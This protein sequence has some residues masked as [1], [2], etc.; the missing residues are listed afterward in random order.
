MSS[1][2]SLSFSLFEVFHLEDLVPNSKDGFLRL[3]VM[4]WVNCRD[5]LETL[6]NVRWTVYL[7]CI[8]N[9]LISQFCKCIN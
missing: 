3:N 5:N 4:L 2:T 1:K 6:L 7:D 9:G 8:S